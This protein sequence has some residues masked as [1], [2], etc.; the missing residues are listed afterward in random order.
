M[1]VQRSDAD[2]AIGWFML[3]EAD[4]AAAARHLASLA[5]DG[6]RDELG[7]APVHFAFADR[8]FPGTSVQHAQLRYVFFVAWS[9]QELLAEHAGGAFPLE[10]LRDIERRYSQRLIDCT[11]DL[12]NSGI[13]GWMKYRAGETPVVR[14]STIYWTALRSWQIARSWEETKSSPTEVDVRRSWA[15]LVNREEAD[16]GRSSARE[17]FDGLPPAPS[18]W[19]RAKGPLTFKLR[20]AEAHYVR[21]HWKTA[22]NGG[23]PLMSKLLVAGLAPKSLWARSVARIASADE[24]RALEL[25]RRAA[26]LTCVARAVHSALIEAKRNSDLKLTQSQHHDALSELV[27]IH[28]VHA[29]ELDVATLRRETGIDGR[30]AAFIEAVQRWLQ[31]GEPFQSLHDVMAQ[32]E[33]EL[34]GGRAYLSNEARRVD[35]NKRAAEPLDYRWSTVR[36]MIQCV[37]EA[38]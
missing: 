25:A 37:L 27:P 5:S 13:S 2:P 15:D 26:S 11:S 14:A 6:T 35:W 31:D 20:L 17:I 1:D 10:R 8:F 32:R 19:G 22:A 7:F 36:R 33:H 29:L 28:S 30:L 24:Q 38:S 9:Y 21:K 18:D 12:R 3:S 23:E 16:G 34:K 4:R